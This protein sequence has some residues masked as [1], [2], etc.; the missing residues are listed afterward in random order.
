MFQT[1]V[2][3]SFLIPLFPLAGFLLNGLLGKRLGRGFVHAVACGTVFLSLLMALGCIGWVVANP[4]QQFEREFTWIPG[5]EVTTRYG[6]DELPEGETA[7]VSRFT[8]T[9]GFLVDPLSAVML[10]VVCFIGFLIHVYSTGYIAGEH[11]PEYTGASWRFFA[12][13]NLFM[14]MMLTLVLG[15]NMLMMFVGWEG[16]GL[17]SYLLIGYYYGRKEAADAGKKAFVVNRVGDF[18]FALGVLACLMIFGT[19]KFTE[20]VPM[21][22]AMHAEGTVAVGTLTAICLLLFV[23]ACGK[24]AQIPLYTWL[25]DAMAGPTPVSALI[26]AATMVTSGIYMIARLSGLFSLAPQALAVI[27][28]VGCATAFVAAT[29][30]LT[31]N[32]IKKVLAYSTVSQ[33]GYMFLALG[34]GAYAAAVFHLMTHA[35]FKAC[36]FLG[37]GSVIHGMHGEQDMRYMGGLWKHM[38]ATAKTFLISTVAIAGVFPLSG[39]FSKDEILWF[40]FSSN[41]LLWLFGF[42]TAGMT[43]F[44][45]FRLVFMTFFQTERFDKDHVHP[46]ESPKSMTVPLWILATGAVVAGWVGIPKAWPLIGHNSWHHWLDPV[47]SDAP[48]LTEATKGASHGVELGMAFVSLAW[49][50]AAIYFAK[51]VFQPETDIP[52]RFAEKFRALYQGS[53]NKWYVDEWYDALI[54]NPLKKMTGVLNLV[55]KYVIDGIVNGCRHVTIALCDGSKVFDLGV[56]DM[57]VNLVGGVVRGFGAA[58]RRFQTGSLQ[59]YAYYFVVGLFVMVCI[60]VLAGGG[61]T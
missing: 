2:E 56:V 46:H 42:L 29:I 40:A 45:M 50:V 43:A 15:N 24:S 11:D 21:A 30:A 59:S 35:F 18:G 55:D 44:Y 57:L 61:L 6:F 47:A 48:V 38:P 19:I 8:A 31:Q 33:L 3:W 58:F 22:V 20:L 9:W 4:D 28:V 53:L 41:K 52:R 36:L 16:V 60:F 39:F 54:V 10:F 14:A 27:A 49:A 7:G 17:C 51:R 23:G 37:S 25:P 13:L 34:C 1:A 32:D 5:Y 26:H 12:Y